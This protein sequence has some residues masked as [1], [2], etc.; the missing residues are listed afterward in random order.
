[1]PQCVSPA[2]ACKSKKTRQQNRI[3]DVN[4]RRSNIHT[5]LPHGRTSPAAPGCAAL[6]RAGL[7]TFPASVRG[8]LVVVPLLPA[9]FSALS[10]AGEGEASSSQT[11]LGDGWGV[12]SLLCQRAV[13]KEAPAWPR[14]PP[15]HSELDPAGDAQQ[16]R[17]KFPECVERLQQGVGG[18]GGCPQ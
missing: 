9:S 16:R 2:L 8:T 3:R 7:G 17:I 15:R 4:P 6:L 12:A 14:P 1:M 5:R 13:F 11:P 10:A 18:A